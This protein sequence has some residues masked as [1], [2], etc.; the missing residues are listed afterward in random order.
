[1]LRSKGVD[2]SLKRNPR[3]AGDGSGGTFGVTV[4]YLF[5]PEVV[6]SGHMS[7]RPQQNGR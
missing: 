1:V 6:Q 4:N 2:K 5:D 3:T 7:A